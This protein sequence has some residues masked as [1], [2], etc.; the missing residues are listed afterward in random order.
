MEPSH[1]SKEF[2]VEEEE[3]GEVNM[4][5]S[6][7]TVFLENKIGVSST[8]ENTKYRFTIDKRVIDLFGACHS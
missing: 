3:C 6:R 4:S 5:R 8:F 1:Y 2:H 7:H